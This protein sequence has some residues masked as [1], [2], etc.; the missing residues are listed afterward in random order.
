MNISAIRGAITVEENAPDAIIKNTSYLLQEIIKRN[1]LQ[2][3]NIISIYFTATEDLDTAY[4][5]VA[6]R[7]LGIT[8]AALMCFQE[9]K[10]VD[11]LQKCIRVVVQVSTNSTQAMMNH[12]YLKEAA[13]LRPD[14][15]QK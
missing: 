9:M 15:I 7:Q 4:P 5:A 12:V 3:S 10:V 2:L 11:S 1:Q 8:Q 14:L 13:K 6:A